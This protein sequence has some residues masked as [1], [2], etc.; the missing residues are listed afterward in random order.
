MFNFI[1]FLW[2]LLLVPCQSLKGLLPLLNEC[3][4]FIQ[5]SLVFISFNLLCFSSFYGTFSL[6]SFP[7]VSPILIPCYFLCAPLSW[8]SLLCLDRL[9]SPPTSSIGSHALLQY[10]TQLSRSWFTHQRGKISHFVRLNEGTSQNIPADSLLQAHYRLFP[11]A[12]V[13]SPVLICQTA[14][15]QIRSSCLY[16]TADNLEC[17]D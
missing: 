4:A 10:I 7:L 15:N 11:W 8:L 13:R 2:Y 5:I 6:F 1:W 17:K 12:S 3:W 14:R 16:C 9:E